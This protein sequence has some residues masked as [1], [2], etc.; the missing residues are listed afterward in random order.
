MPT[1]SWDAKLVRCTAIVAV[2]IAPVVITLW[3]VRAQLGP[4]VRRVT[5]D[6]FV[7]DMLV[8]VG[9]AAAMLVLGALIIVWLSRRGYRPQIVRPLVSG[10]AL[11]GY[12]IIVLVANDN[13]L[14]TIMGMWWILPFF[15][16]MSII[17]WA[18][19]QRV[20]SERFCAKCD[21]PYLDDPS[22]G[23]CPECGSAW[24]GRFGVVTGRKQTNRGLVRVGAGVVAF[25]FGISLLGSLLPGVLLRMAPTS[26]LIYQAVHTRSFDV[27]YWTVL[28]ARTLT[29]AQAQTLAQGLLDARLSSGRMSRDDELWIDRQA[30]TNALSPELAKRY[31]A[32]M[33]GPPRIVRVPASTPMT[34]D[35]ARAVQLEAELRTNL[36]NT[37]DSRVVVEGWWVD[38]VFTPTGDTGKVLSTYALDPASTVT[39]SIG[40]IRLVLPPEANGPVRV[41]FVG[42]IAIGPFPGVAWQGSWSAAPGEAGATPVVPGAT[43]WMERFEV[44]AVIG[45]K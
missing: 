11:L 39:G 13:G 8:T 28:N 29:P 18:A 1:P 2:A 17:G 41:K 23:R 19:H 14:S 24:G 33:V 9:A 21:Y 27:A 30:R 20:G 31:F 42:W 25:G 16:G 40:P 7:T 37:Q 45:V 15:V 43:S 22:A 34:P 10:A 35:G 3:L 44:E 32:E 38:G 12:A 6:R 5:L 26:M 4:A 36:S